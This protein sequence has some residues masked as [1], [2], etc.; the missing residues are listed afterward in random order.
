MIIKAAEF[1]K[2]AVTPEQ[3]PSGNLPE[4]AFAGRSNAGKSSLINKMVNR[5]SLAKTSAEAGKT[6]LI[7]FFLIN[8]GFYFVDLPGYGYAKASHG[9]REEWKPMIENYVVSRN[10]L[11]GMVVI[12]DVRRDPAVEEIRL[13]HWLSAIKVPSIWV[14]SKADKVSRNDQCG[15]RDA[16][17]TALCVNKQDVILFS[18]K[19]GQGRDE[20]WHRMPLSF[21]VRLPENIR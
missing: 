7:N 9:E 19:T 3:C 8:K 14:L 15:S 12:S 16:F 10:T 17:T 20:L 21:Q 2:S 1:I 11:K 5:K 6:R 4:I 13:G 18:S